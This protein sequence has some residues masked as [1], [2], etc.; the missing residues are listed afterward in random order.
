MRKKLFNRILLFMAITS[1]AVAMVEGYFYYAEYEAFPMFRFMLMLQNSV[2]AFAFNA[3][4]SL[5]SIIKNFSVQR[6]L[7]QVLVDY[8]YA[9]IVFVA[10]LCTMTFLYK[11]FETVLK[12]NIQLHKDKTSEKILIFGYNDRVKALLAKEKGLSAKHKRKIQII[13]AGEVPSYDELNLLEKG[14]TVISFECLGASGVKLK[15]FYRDIRIKQAAVILL[16]EETYSKNFSLYHMLNESEEVPRHVKLYCN[17][18]EESIR[19]IIESYYDEAISE[20]REMRK[21]LELIDVTQIQARKILQEHPLYAYY[22]GSQLP[23]DQWNIHMLVLGFG[24]LGQQLVLQAMTQGVV[25]SENRILIDVVD[26]QIEELK[27][28]FENH[29]SS[30]YFE[31]EED[32][33]RVKPGGADGELIIRFRKMDL[34]YKKFGTLLESLSEEGPFTYTAICLKD[35]DISLHC[36]L[37]LER[38]FAKHDQ[39]RADIGIR[40]DVDQR[41]A[42]YL[43]QD[44]NL[45]KNVFAMESIQHALSLNDIL[46]SDI[47]EDAKEYAYIYSTMNVCGIGEL[48][49]QGSSAPNKSKDEIW[50]ELKLFQRDSNRDLS[51]HAAVKERAIQAFGDRNVLLYRYF[52]P[53]GVLK[54]VDGCWVFEGT[55]EALVKQI[56]EDPFLREMARLE[57]RRWCYAMAIRGW[58]GT[59]GP[60]REVL[61]EN[62]CMVNWDQLCSTV[63][64]TCKYDLQPLMLMYEQMNQ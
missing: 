34:R 11:V 6:P 64:H 10:P 33:L 14:V 31:I 32:E 52:G 62:P 30:G 57:H 23:L 28:I 36:V 18:E 49:L 19:R 40:M 45:H 61:R 27:S 56:N 12:W 60:K 20:R 29:F 21:D 9:V 3:D 46:A 26:T 44:Q 15:K 63:P 51:C 4:I 38:F 42:Q 24:K 54:K 16:M 13:T 59:K 41:V 2:E 7:F 35:Q 5:T 47:N 25:H 58:K 53:E 39:E 22:E 1:F 17:C 55:E 48:T 50:R 43:S 8:I 37:E